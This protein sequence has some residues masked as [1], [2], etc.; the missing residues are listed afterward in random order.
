[1]EHLGQIEERIRCLE[2][3]VFRARQ[4]QRWRPS[5]APIRITNYAGESVTVA[6]LQAEEDRV[7]QEF[8]GVDVGGEM[9]GSGRMGKRKASY[10]VAKALGV[11]TNQGEGF[12]TNLFHC[13]ICLDKAR[14]PVLTSC[15]HLFCWPCFHKLSYA[16]SHVRECPVCKGD[17]T[18]EGIIPIYGNA[19]VDNN[20]KFESN[21]IGLTVPARPRPHRI[22]SIRQRFRY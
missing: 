17:V 16:Y 21:E 13:N 19:S 8:G 5:Q 15:G 3:V 1:M 2:A 12:A 9:M 20:G 6:D 11:E 4:R 14:D 10:L 18:E 7:H 22:E